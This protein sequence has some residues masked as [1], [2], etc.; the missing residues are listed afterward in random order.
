M[1]DLWNPVL[2]VIIL[3]SLALGS[4]T[5]TRGHDWG[6]DFASYIMQGQSILNGNL[7]GFVEH[8]SFTIFESSFQIGP[9]AYPWG[10]P[11]V[12][13][14]ALLLK[15]VH[16]LTLK[17]PGLVLFGG[18]LICLY[19]WTK[20]RLT[21][22]ES[23]LLVSVF[24]FN[25]TLIK[26]LDQILS[27]IPLLFFTGLGLLLILNLKLEDPL[28][29]YFVL[30]AALFF[31][32]FVRTTGIILLAS[33]LAYRFIEFIRKSESRRRIL[34][35]SAAATFVL[36]ALWLG[37]SQIFPNGQGSYL[38]QLK[39]L[40]PAIIKDNI[41]NYFHLFAFFFGAEPIWIYLY[42]GLTIFFLI[43]MWTRRSTDQ[44]LIIF[45]ALYF[46]AM[47]FW[48]EWQGIRFI[49]PLLPIFVYFA[50]QGMRLVINKIPGKYQQVSQGAFYSYWLL[51]IGIFLFNSGLRAY[52]N[53]QGNRQIN[54]PFDPVSSDV[55]NY[56]RTET[57][58]D[59]VIVFWKPR[60]M[61]LFTDHDTFMSTE[62]DR[63]P[64]GDYVVISKKA[65]NSQV[66]PDKI[67]QCNLRLNHVFENQRFIIYEVPE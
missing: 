46:I 43:G 31:A 47:L 36:V 62:C 65:E 12:L 41:S 14:P 35:N 61:R 3:L 26:F 8:N 34:G 27:D 16:P 18:F 54:G 33:F 13:T 64:L 50:F 55:Y 59:S 9:V 1:R 25:P 58:P 10:Y 23:L 5:L 39:E 52:E 51:L 28:W 66:P 20:N 4:A 7:A 30:G 15:G 24:A 56:I 29:K 44:P 32:V 60:A 45:F 19:A 6:D 49:F 40:T 53:L 17:L 67:D 22:T 11:L 37:T 2:V 38:E 42:F 63:L 21:P 48:P 57:P